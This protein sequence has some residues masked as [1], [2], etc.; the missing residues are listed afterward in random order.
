MDYLCSGVWAHYSGFPCCEAWALW[1]VGLVA[2]VH[3]LQ[4]PGSLVTRHTVLVALHVGSSQTGIKPMFPALA[5]G[6]FTA[7]LAGKP[8]TTVFQL[9]A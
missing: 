4:S 8:S 7:E 2:A 1:L 5:G 9:K 3:G 6:F